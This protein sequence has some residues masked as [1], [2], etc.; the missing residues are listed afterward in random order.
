MELSPFKVVRDGFGPCSRLVPGEAAVQTETFSSKFIFDIFLICLPKFAT[1]FYF[2]TKG[3][4]Q[5]ALYTM[6]CTQHEHVHNT[7]LHVTEFWTGRTIPIGRR[8]MLTQ[9]MYQKWLALP[10]IR[11]PCKHHHSGDIRTR[12]YQLHYPQYATC[13]SCCPTAKLF[14]VQKG[15]IEEV[16]NSCGQ[17]R[18][19]GKGPRGQWKV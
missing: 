12:L 16:L 13:H 2:R 1:T 6:S 3:C 18:T 4:A 15:I 7:T 17:E 8:F 11:R 10:H 5:L 9:D 19:H 14:L